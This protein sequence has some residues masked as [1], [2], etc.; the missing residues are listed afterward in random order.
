MNN[1][2]MDAGGGG[3]NPNDPGGAKTIMSDSPK[4]V[5]A[6]SGGYDPEGAKTVMGDSGGYDPEGAKTVMGNTPGQD[7]NAAKT[8]MA[9]TSGQQRETPRS[10]PMDP[11]APSP[12]APPPPPPP[13]PAANDPMPAPPRFAPSPAPEQ[14]GASATMMMAPPEPDTPLAWLGI[15]SGP[16]GSRGQT[17]VLRPETVIGRVKGEVQLGNDKTISSQH[18]KI[19][20]EPKDDE[21]EEDTVWVLYDLA[22]ANGT[23]VGNRDNYR[24]ETSRVY[25]R[26]LH[27]GDYILLGE[28]TV[29]FLE[30]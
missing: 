12:W 21:S 19:R 26:E 11:G 27:Q 2:T 30:P 6:N 14:A 28:T 18:A 20:L 29:V 8:I 16:G 1:S 4:T 13:P 17:F 25:R 5:M 3:Y 23:F 22:S 24:D 9:D 15:I 7:P 10:L